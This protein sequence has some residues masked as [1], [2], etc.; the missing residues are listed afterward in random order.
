ML[1]FL[2]LLFLQRLSRDYIKNKVVELVKCFC[3]CVSNQVLLLCYF[4]QG[5]AKKQMKQV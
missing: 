3:S 1:L 2:L 4:T 5:C